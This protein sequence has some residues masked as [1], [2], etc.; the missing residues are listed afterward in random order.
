VIGHSAPVLKLYF[1]AIK[2]R[3]FR[4]GA[5]LVLRIVDRTT[6]F[7][8]LVFVLSTLVTASMTSCPISSLSTI[9]DA[10]YATRVLSPKANSE[11]AAILL[12]YCGVGRIMSGCGML[13]VLYEGSHMQ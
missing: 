6:R 1:R 4:F 11:N 10:S 8:R 7:Q 12:Q 5:L 13:D 3:I 9:Q 2:S